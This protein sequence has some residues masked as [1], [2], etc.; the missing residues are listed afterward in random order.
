MYY[1]YIID[2]FPRSS[3]YSIRVFSDPQ[4]DTTL[5][6]LNVFSNARDVALAGKKKVNYLAAFGFS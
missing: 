1:I 4:N 6:I 5:I 2:F 3:A